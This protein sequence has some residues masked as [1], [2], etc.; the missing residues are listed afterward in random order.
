MRQFFVT[1]FTPFRWMRRIW[2]RSLLFRVTA[3][4]VVLSSIVV[5]V[6]GFSL[7]SRVTTGLLDA[8]EV[9]SVGEASAGL[10]EAQ[11][12]LDAANTGP[13]TP[14]PAR[15]VDSVVTI[16]GSRSGSPATFEVLLLSSGNQIDAPERGTNLVAVSSIPV[17]LRESIQK[18]KRQ[19]WTFS[20]IN[21][22]DGRVTPGLIVGAPL[23]VPTVGP[24]ELYYLFPLE[25]EQETLDLVSSSVVGT[26]IV[27]VILVAV[28]ALLV[29]RQVVVPVREAARIARRFSSGK[30]SERMQ[31]KKEDDL[32]QLARSFNDM[33]QSLATQIRQLE[34]L[35]QLQQR[36]VSD[37]SHELR[38]PLTTIRMAADVMYEDRGAFDA[39]TAR[40]VELL[41][42]QLDRFE[43]LLVD[44][45]EISRF[46]AGAAV[47]DVERVDLVALVERIIVASEPL[48]AR[49][50]LRVRFAAYEKPCLVECDP[51][52]IDRVMRNLLDN[53]IEHANELGVVV[54]LAGN[55]SAISVT[56]R[57]F[58]VGLHP[59][60]ASLVFSRFWRADKA[61]ARTTG[62][63]GLGLAIALEDT[64]LH[65][66]WLEAWGEPGQGACFRLTLP[67]VI[68]GSIDGPALA[69]FEDMDSEV[70]RESTVIES[71]VIEPAPH[72]MLEPGSPGD[73]HWRGGHL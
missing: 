72:G 22:L 40:S 48:A 27:L 15:L 56:V 10:G 58:G 9:S 36:F 34:E 26:G 46:D 53:A 70:P 20:P 42:T 47:L 61:R 52:R 24:Y 5:T 14:S 60:E 23:T 25:Q 6:L 67:R 62:G 69:L 17:D 16:L 37:V 3:S 51:R 65:A 32:A 29:T 18:N 63:T 71:S 44:L 41:Q 4:T 49:N 43:A 55:E 66:G 8:K 64:R 33:A 19:S 2:R 73:A 31:V 30:L 7:L 45:L 38:T 35:S 39:S 13:S 68:G 1:I 12:L 11:R 54:E 21:F 59:G 57:D 28:V 50:N